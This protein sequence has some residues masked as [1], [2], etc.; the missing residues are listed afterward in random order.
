M[1]SETVP[2]K[3]IVNSIK[4]SLVMLDTLP[5]L[6]YVLIEDTAGDKHG[7]GLIPHRFGL[8]VQSVW[9]C[10]E[11]QSYHST[12]VSGWEY[13]IIVACITHTH[14][15]IYIHTC[16]CV[17][18]CARIHV[19]TCA[20]C[21]FLATHDPYAHLKAMA[22]LMLLV[23]PHRTTSSWRPRGRLYQLKS[24]ERRRASSK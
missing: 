3:P 22:Q 11:H 7:T 21:A 1:G 2:G 13:A 4:E 24:S 12:R 16:I 15:Y 17:C 5:D 10:L 14:I 18:L 20:T 23:K 19:R 6:D 9:S 8:L